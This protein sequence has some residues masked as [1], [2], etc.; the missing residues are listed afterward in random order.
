MTGGIGHNFEAKPIKGI[1]WSS[2]LT[3]EQIEEI[4]TKDLDEAISNASFHIP[5]FNFLSEVRQCVIVDMVFNMGIHGVLKFRNFLS[6]L[7]TNNWDRART[8]MFN[9]LWAFQVGDGP[10][11]REDRVDR[12]S[13][14]LVTN[15]WLN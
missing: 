13:Y 4:F 1:N 12:L 9:S 10:G 15:E 11:K 7:T 8:E 2:V 14:M 3:D 6:A 5:V